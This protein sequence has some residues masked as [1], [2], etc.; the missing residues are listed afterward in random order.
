MVRALLYLRLTSLGNLLRSRLL[1]L[2]QPKYL[3]GAVVGV[4]YFYFVLF[5]HGGAHPA[6]A[7]PHAAATPV[8]PPE[9]LTVYTAFGALIFLVLITLSWLVPSQRA[10]LTFSEAEIAF[11]FPAPLTRRSL[12]HY[13][14]LSSQIAILFTALILTFLSRRG[15]F[16]GGDPVTHAIGWWFILAIL[17]LHTIGASFVIT[18]LLD[19]GVTPLRRRLFILGGIALVVGGALLWVW[20]DLPKAGAADLQN[21]T[22]IIAWLGRVIATPAL[23]WLLLPAKLV[24]GP[25]L[26]NDLPAF[27]LALGP[28]VAIFALHYFW[29]FRVEVSFEEASIAKAEKRAAKVA[30]IRE[31]KGLAARPAAARPG[32]FRLAATGRPELAFLWK[33]LLGTH[34]FFRPRTFYL[35]AGILCVLC[36]WLAVQPGYRGMLV[37]VST[38]ALIAGG[39]TLFLGPQL[40]RQDLRSDLPN[41]DLLKTYPLRGWQLVLGE[42]LTPVAI[43]TALLWLALLTLAL[44]LHTPRLDAWLTAPLRFELVLCLGLIAPLVCALQL[45][46]PNAATLLFPAWMQSMRNRTERGIEVVGQRI[47]FVAGQ[48]LIVLLALLPAALL[49]ALLI[50]ALQWLIGL[51][52]AVLLA[53]VAV[54]AILV[55]EIWLGLWWLGERFE[56]FDLSGELRP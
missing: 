24:L 12:I 21:L 29:I 9:L 56:R 16:G 40:A 42:L 20:H 32:P 39:Y 48:V 47:I 19:R 18:R 46:V 31:G 44:S 33:N 53:T 17:N 28:A 50:F 1:R 35:A 10:G 13:K 52:A 22:A 23:S 55:G 30:A 37:V 25:F 27:A 34:P 54:A 2:R 14:L 8:L 15:I 26:A 51:A 43:L 6:P 7:G 3:A 45:L 4:A 5:R 38:F 41:A 36:T 11:L 49:A